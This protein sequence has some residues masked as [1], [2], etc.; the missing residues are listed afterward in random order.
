MYDTEVD[1]QVVLCKCRT[2]TG[3]GHLSSAQV[4]S[5]MPLHLTV[6]DP[7]SVRGTYVRT[8]VHAT[9]HVG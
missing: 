8:H 1:T 3:D 2:D 4:G 5:P 9:E 6:M 7:L